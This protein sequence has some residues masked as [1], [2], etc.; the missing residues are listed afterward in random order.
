[1]GTEPGFKEL[2]NLVI[3]RGLCN[4]CGTCIGT[5]PQQCLT[6]SYGEDDEPVVVEQS[7]CVPCGV[8]TKVCPGADIPM[9][10]LER[11]LFDRPR[12]KSEDLGIFLR[13]GSA[14]ATDKETRKG[15]SS[16]GLVS[17][18]LIHA[19]ESGFIDCAIVT[20]FSKEVP[21]RPQAL[22]AT[23]RDQILAAAKSK[24]STTA[25]NV[26][27]YRA[28]SQGYQKIDVVGC[29]CHIHGIRKILYFNLPAK[30]A[31]A[32][33]VCVGI[34][35]ASQFYFEGMRHVLYEWCGVKER[36]DIVAL[37]H[38]G[39][40]W[41]EHNL[42]VTLRNGEQR[43]MPNLQYM[44]YVLAH[45]KQDRCE[46]CLDWASELS[47]ISAGDYWG[48]SPSPEERRRTAFLV[49]TKVGDDLMKG[50]EN[51]GA[52]ALEQINPD[53]FPASVGYEY[54][55]H[56]NAFRYL[57]RQKYGWPTPNFHFRPDYFPT[58]KVA[59]AMPL[60]KARLDRG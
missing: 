59:A 33:R 60:R 35:C 11:F 18:L 21:W 15:S 16:G 10:D 13:C 26:L 17:A 6:L 52:I 2:K 50:A 14:I 3:E 7:P 9:P 49:R 5:C 56:C 41:P 24:Y 22:I 54:K 38:R 27:L 42:V 46:V 34:H 40:P 8:C 51:S 1:M 31:S 58:D 30:V 55:K 28:V 36:G 32:V 53:W 20:G 37:E 44:V 45:W 23:T 12:T 19:L 43:R 48:P 39:G 29:P 25:A 57:Q 47:D 4:A